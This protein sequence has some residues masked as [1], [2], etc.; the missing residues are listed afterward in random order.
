M[1]PGTPTPYRAPGQPPEKQGFGHSK[2]RLAAEL[3]LVVGA[4]VVVVAVA[5]WLIGAMAGFIVPF[6]PTDA[7][8]AVGESAWAELAPESK[9]CTH[10]EAQK[11]VEAI[12]APL[13]AE[14]PPD[15]GFTFT[16]AV[17]DDE[18]VNAFALPG[19]FIVVNRGLLEKAA[20][21]A[22]VAAV[23]A[24]EIQHVMER[25]GFERIVT[26]MGAWAIIST[27]LGV[28]DLQSLTALGVG[29]LGNAYG[30][31]AE[32]EAD[33]GGL[34]LLVAAGI[35][36]SGMSRFFERLQAEG[37]AVPAILSTHP[38]PGE[39]AERA[40]KAAAALGGSAQVTLPAP[41]GVP[42]R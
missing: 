28:A 30:R 7:D 10:P 33:G 29:L 25:H 37:Q 31:D 5:W 40:A 22:E 16:F 26:T 24:H 14:L 39:R 3:G 18:T 15:H 27:L 41:E 2:N 17:L 34:D 1:Q 12:A 35:D 38:D 20:D 9:R 8:V 36:P 19:G 23:M 42:C 13:L 6:I 4:I 21:G 11:Y 32:R